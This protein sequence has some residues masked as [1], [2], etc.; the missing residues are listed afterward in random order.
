MRRLLV[1]PKWWTVHVLVVV[2]VIAFVRLGIWQ[3]DVSEATRGTAQNF[4]Y[5]VEWWLFAGAGVFF[6]VKMIREELHPSPKPDAEASEAAAVDSPYR[7]GRSPRTVVIDDEEE[8]EEL[9]AYNRR[10]AQLNAR[11]QR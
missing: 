5:A 2:V 8:D 6:W 7:P 11:S 10:L 9:A 3:W 4:F 1:S